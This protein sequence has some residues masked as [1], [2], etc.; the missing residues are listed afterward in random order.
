[1]DPLNSERLYV[2]SATW[3]EQLHQAATQVD[4]DLVLQ[5]IR[6]IPPEHDSLALALAELVNHY[7][8]DRLV[9]ITQ[10]QL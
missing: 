10:P 5:L 9:A 3:R 8:F 6:Q 7:R 2:M 1:A 4:A